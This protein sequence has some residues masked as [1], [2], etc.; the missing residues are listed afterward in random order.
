MW[1][2]DA[3]DRLAIWLPIDGGAAQPKGPGLRS[4][5][6]MAPHDGKQNRACR[7]ADLSKCRGVELERE[8]NNPL[9][10]HCVA[11]HIPAVPNDSATSNR[12]AP[13]KVFRRVSN[14]EVMEGVCLGG[15]RAG[16][17][18]NTKLVVIASRT[19]LS[20]MLAS[21]SRAIQDPRDEQQARSW[22]APSSLGARDVHRPVHRP[23]A[24]VCSPVLP[25]TSRVALAPARGIRP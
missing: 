18:R 1:L 5:D 6:R 8:P 24:W 10:R 23:D 25:G 7:A 3:S 19:D 15:P 21:G 16:Q 4:R 22:V 11:K 9:W 13:A 20:A 2:V 14:C 17:E 12:V